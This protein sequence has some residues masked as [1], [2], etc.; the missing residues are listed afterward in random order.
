VAATLALQRSA[1]TFWYRLPASGLPVLGEEH[2]GPEGNVPDVIMGLGTARFMYEPF[3]ELTPTTALGVP[4]PGT[5]ARL[6]TADQ[7]V[8]VAGQVDR[9]LSTPTSRTSSSRR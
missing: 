6:D 8:E 5:Q 9:K 2:H 1:G 3:D 7:G 4:A